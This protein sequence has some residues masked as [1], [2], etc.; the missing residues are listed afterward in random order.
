MKILH[1]LLVIVFVAVAAAKAL[2]RGLSADGANFA[3]TAFDYVIIGGG[4]A[5]LTIAARLS[6]D[7]ETT[8]GVIE[9]GEYLPEDPLINTPGLAFS[10][11]GNEK[12]DW[13]FKSAPQVNANN[14]VL[15]LPRGKILGGSSGINIMT[16][17]R[18]SK[19]EYDAWAKLGN[20]GWDW[21]GLLPNMKAA[22]RFMDWYS[23]VVPP[24][25]KSMANLGVPI[26]FDPDSGN[27]VG[28][29]NS[30][31]SIN[32][33]T[34]RRS[35]A[36]TTYYAYNAHRH[37]LVVLTGAQATKINF[38]DTQ[39]NKA[40]NVVATGVS[41]VHKS[42]SYA[43]K[44][45]KEVIISAGTFQ[46]PH[47]LELSGIGNSAILQKNGIKPVVDLPGVGEN[48]QDHMFVATSFELKPGS[49]KENLDLLRNNA[50]F[51]A[52]AAARYNSTHDGI[53]S[54]PPSALSFVSL[55]SMASSAEIEN[56]AAQLEREIASE[57]PS[58]LQQKSY[59]IQKGWLKEKLGLVEIIGY[60]GFAGAGTPKVNSSYITLF[61]AVQHPFSRGSIR[62]H[63]NTSD[64]LAAPWI[65]PNYFSK[66]IDL[67]TLVY[68]VKFG[69]KL[70]KTEP[71]ASMIASRQYPPPEVTSDADIADFVKANVATIHH[72]IG[73]CSMAPR[74]SGGVVD[75]HMK[76]H[77]TA[78]VR[79]VDASV[80]PLHIGS[81]L[82]RTVYGIAEKT[83]K[84]IKEG[85]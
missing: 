39:R 78:N 44:V 23:D 65:D 37:N 84:L 40:G 20:P 66:S 8:V 57:K 67:D 10:I 49:S 58:E 41:F 19:V 13:L 70:S 18:G 50:T 48:Y 54:S 17:D 52:V 26:N 53:L 30:A 71:L 76:V 60:P 4:T 61:T 68:A 11:M 15:N 56:M 33:T 62:K 42:Q 74:E 45:K 69:H 32:R 9:T 85:F 79:V 14:R 59:E 63:I 46:S 3:S 28:S 24:L 29:F 80:M 72:P 22:E 5:G 21:E 2:Q 31:T 64:P 47:L 34:G 1:F 36:A 75:A 43:V 73:T 16:F 12:Y 81:H 82:Q 38:K 77:G 27:A 51:A 55:T 83:A 7:P 25:R 35:Y 6:E